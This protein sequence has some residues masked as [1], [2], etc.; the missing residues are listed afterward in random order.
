MRHAK[1]VLFKSL[2]TWERGL[3]RPA[4]SHR[5]AHSRVA[6]YVGAWIETVWYAQ[7]NY[8]MDSRSLRGSVD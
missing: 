2:P 8:T 6:P 3:K 5:P 4:R 1:E 7:Y